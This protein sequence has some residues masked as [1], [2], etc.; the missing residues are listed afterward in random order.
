MRILFLGYP[1]CTVLSFLKRRANVFQTMKR[2]KDTRI[3]YADLTVCFGYRFLLKPQALNK[4]T[5]PPINLH[6]SFLPFNRGAN[7]NY[8]SF[9]DD[10]PKGVTIHEID[11]GL[12]TGSIMFRRKIVFTSKEDDIAKTYARLFKEVQMLFI[13]KWER[14]RISDYHPWKQPE[15]GSF[16]AL[17]DMPEL[18]EGWNTKIAGLQK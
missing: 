1:D 11:Q 12:D 7:P 4:A 13:D 8:W 14:I 15:G 6:I 2:V 16:H 18:A 5:R 10:T 9:V 3:E 17:G